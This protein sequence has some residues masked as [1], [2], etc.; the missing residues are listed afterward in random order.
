MIVQT[1][2]TDLRDPNWTFCNEIKLNDVISPMLAQRC[3]WVGQVEQI[4]KDL[5]EVRA[6]IGICLH[7]FLGGALR[8]II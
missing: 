7:Y 2:C 8:L 1:V 6:C 3:T 5:G 4:S